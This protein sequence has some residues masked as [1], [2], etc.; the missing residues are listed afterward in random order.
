MALVTF[1]DNYWKLLKDGPI[2][3]FPLWSTDLPL[4]HKWGKIEAQWSEERGESECHIG[5]ALLTL[6]REHLFTD[7]SP[8]KPGPNLCG[9]RAAAVDQ[10]LT[11]H[12]V[13]D[14]AGLMEPVLVI[15]S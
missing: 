3:Y 5:Q 2:V 14:C 11:G 7:T 8:H 10:W 6:Q 13:H 4:L 9:A 15:T 12:T 1:I